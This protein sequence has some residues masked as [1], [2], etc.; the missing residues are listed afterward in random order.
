MHPPVLSQSGFPSRTLLWAIMSSLH[1]GGLGQCGQDRGMRGSEIGNAAEESTKIHDEERHRCSRSLRVVNLSAPPFVE[2]GW[3]AKY[4]DALFRDMRI[5]APQ[6]VN[7]SRSLIY[8]TN[9]LRNQSQGWVSFLYLLLFQHIHDQL[10]D[11]LYTFRFDCAHGHSPGSSPP[12]MLTI[13]R[14]R[15]LTLNHF[16]QVVL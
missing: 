11:N 13:A 12:C 8:A 5:A 15:L 1:L 4:P 7:T 6:E 14:V 3:L 10:R 9:M 2:V 16:L